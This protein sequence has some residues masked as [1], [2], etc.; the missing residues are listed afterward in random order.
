M[1]HQA[2]HNLTKVTYFHRRAVRR[3]RFGN[4][5]DNRKKTPYHRHTQLM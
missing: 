2:F 3:M 1:L 5:I 4:D